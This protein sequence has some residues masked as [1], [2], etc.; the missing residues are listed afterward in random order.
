MNPTFC[1]ICPDP[2]QM[3]DSDFKYSIEINEIC[4]LYT[5]E[6]FDD[7]NRKR[8]SGS[9]QSTFRLI[10][11]H[12]YFWAIVDSDT[13]TAI[14]FAY[15]YNVSGGENTPYSACFSSAFHPK[16]WGKP[17]TQATQGFLEIVFDV[18]ELSKLSAEVF[19]HNR[20]PQKRLAKMG[21]EFEH[22]TI[23][24]TL[25]NG[26]PSEILTYSLFNTRS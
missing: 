11:D 14:G 12:K 18:F 6:L 16:Y 25:C 17:V 22:K 2:L 10:A 15:L 26:A 5:T 9:L 3:R 21:F 20:Y 19:A 7:F 13:L 8:Y 23:G 24:N 4:N 1:P